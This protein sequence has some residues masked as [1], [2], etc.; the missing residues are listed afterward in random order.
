MKLLLENL[1]NEEL[2]FFSKYFSTN[3]KNLNSLP[4]NVKLAPTVEVADKNLEIAIN[5]AKK[6]ILD[7]PASLEEIRKESEIARRIFRNSGNNLK[8]LI[9]NIEGNDSLKNIFVKLLG[10]NNYENL[11]RLPKFVKGIRKINSIRQSN[12]EG[13]YKDFTNEINELEALYNN[14]LSKRLA[15][16]TTEE[17]NYFPY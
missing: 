6:A 7:L 5:A 13:R 1:T 17:V 10:A 9:N 14:F 4:D 3:A 8:S 16:I 15:S 2:E 11:Y 12:G